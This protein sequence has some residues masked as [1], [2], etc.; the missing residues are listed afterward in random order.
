MP[1]PT[2]DKLISLFFSTGRII[3]ERLKPPENIDPSSMLRLFTLRYVVDHPAAT[4]SEV[5]DFLGITP[6]SATS[7]IDGLVKARHIKRT[8][9]AA[10]R[11]VVRLT[12]T[13]AGRRAMKEWREQIHAR[14]RTVF[15]LLSEADQQEL[16]RIL[17][18]ISHV[19]EQQST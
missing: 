19:A 10:D 17:Q 13:V 4:M 6:P 11:R 16:M 12:I 3:R 18:K 14:M 8:E 5:S 1:K 7:L 15:S 2:T 9:D